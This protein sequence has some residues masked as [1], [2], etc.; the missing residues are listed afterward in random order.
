MRLPH[1]ARRLLEALFIIF[2]IVTINFVLIRFMPGDPVVHI[3]GEDEYFRLESEH[4]EVIEEVRHEYG[5]DRSIGVQYLTYLG[6]TAQLDFGNSYRVKTP[7]LETVLFRMQWT[8]LLTIPAILLAALLGGFLGLWAGW[9]RGGIWDTITSTVM[10]LISTVPT[11][12]LAILFLL[13]FAFKLGKFPISGITSGGLSGVARSLDI[14]WHMA[15]PLAVLVILRTSSYFML[16][17]STVQSIKDEEYVTVARSKGFTDARVLRRHVLKNALC[18]YITSVC[19]QFGHILGGS[20]LVEVVFSWKGMG[21]LIYDSVNA[22]DFPM[23]QTCFLFIGIC[24][25]CFNLLA[26]VLNMLI[27]PR[28]RKEGKGWR[29]V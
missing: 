1:I 6:K 25:V 9:N 15:L 21:T 8:L 4:P 11:N 29:K 26:D 14:L 10:M 12:A 18:P 17:K 22:K 13:F 23:L 3:I 27:D 7:V 19:M 2:C 5:L 20:M 28:T 16:M 24:I